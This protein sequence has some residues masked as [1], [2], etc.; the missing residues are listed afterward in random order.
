[1]SEVQT[2]RI[3]NPKGDGYV[4]INASDFDSSR[5]QLYSDTPAPATPSTPATPAVVPQKESDDATQEQT[6]PQT[7]DAALASVLDRP[8]GEIYPLVANT[9]FTVDQLLA[10][11]TLEGKGKARKTVLEALET[12][13]KS[14]QPTE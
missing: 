10:L 4:N 9:E 2:V 7:V 13:A 6:S 5:H 8:A 1:M 12:K 14:L 11:Y 3:Q